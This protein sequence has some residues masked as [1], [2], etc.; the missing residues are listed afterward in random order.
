LNIQDAVLKENPYTIC[1]VT[2]L[3]RAIQIIDQV[4]IHAFMQ[5][6]FEAEMRF[7]PVRSF[8]LSA[9]KAEMRHTRG[10]LFPDVLDQ[11]G[12]STDRGIVVE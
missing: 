7:W 11:I 6:R 1:S 9:F 8:M 4:G 2:D 5:R 10:L 12:P 3:E